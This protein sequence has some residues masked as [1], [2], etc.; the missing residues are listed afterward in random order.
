MP[1]VSV[2]STR[3]HIRRPTVSSATSGPI[4]IT[5]PTNAALRNVNATT[6][7]HTHRRERN[8]DQ[9]WRSSVSG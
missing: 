9:P 3:P 6:T 4:T 7:I 5:A 8:S 2:A 1:A